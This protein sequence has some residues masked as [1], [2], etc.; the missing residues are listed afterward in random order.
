MAQCS[1]KSQ[2]RIRV[3][4]RESQIQFALFY[5]WFL[6]FIGVIFYLPKF[7]QISLKLFG[8]TWKYILLTS[9]YYLLF[10]YFFNVLYRTSPQQYPTLKESIILLSSIRKRFYGERKQTRSH[11]D[12]T[13]SLFMLPVSKRELRIITVKA[14]KIPF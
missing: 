13:E 5:R 2:G 10:S 7:H 12:V 9:F 8:T 1:C 6:K 11:T 4:C 3:F 14:Q